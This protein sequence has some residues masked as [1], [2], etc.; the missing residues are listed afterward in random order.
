MVERYGLARN[1]EVLPIYV[2]VSR[3]EALP[4][5]PERG[6][7]LWIGRFTS[8]KHP[9]RAIRALTRA[10][11][12]GH[13][14]R[15]TVLGDGPQKESLVALAE[16]LGITAYVS[17][18]GWQDPA[19][20]LPRAELVLATSSYEGYGMAIVEALAAGV[21]V[22]STD[23]GIAREAG[24]VIAKGDYANALQSW[25]SGSRARGALKLALYQG[26]EDYARKVHSFYASVAERNRAKVRQ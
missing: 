17:F 13:G 11:K 24:A 6:S 20:Y 16:E 25:L 3:F 18:P 7:L 14:V 15:L 19:D 10:R 5:T 4:R 26:W 21:P 12:A 23:V 2:D 22:L 1:F 8:E 9:G